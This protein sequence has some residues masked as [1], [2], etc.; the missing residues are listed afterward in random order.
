MATVINGARIVEQV[1]E[2]ANEYPDGTII[3]QDNY[4][5]AKEV[6]GRY[7]KVKLKMCCVYK[8]EWMDDQLCLITFTIW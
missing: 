6:C 5:H 2:F 3:P 8:T 7:P 1:Y 4:D